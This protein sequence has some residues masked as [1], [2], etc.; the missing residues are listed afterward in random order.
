MLNF[1]ASCNHRRESAESPGCW[2][3]CGSPCCCSVLV[4][5]FALHVVASVG[6]FVRH[7]VFLFNT[8][9]KPYGC[10]VSTNENLSQVARQHAPI[11]AYRL[12]TAGNVHATEF[13]LPPLKGGS[14][15]CSPV[16]RGVMAKHANH[17]HA[18]A[19]TTPTSASWSCSQA[20]KRRPY[21][22]SIAK[23]GSQ[24][25]EHVRARSPWPIYR[26]DPYRTYGPHGGR[27]GGG[28]TMEVSLWTW[29][30][31]KLILLDRKY[32]ISASVHVC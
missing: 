31:L 28:G 1:Q 15:Q 10:V 16:V 14:R 25:C 26:N 17:P 21:H 5:M 3:C 23:R 12:T 30:S 18:A 29:I 27:E 32:W 7:L 20:T 24:A 4:C 9:V 2:K 8:C 13:V 11:I 22:W 19:A 6:R